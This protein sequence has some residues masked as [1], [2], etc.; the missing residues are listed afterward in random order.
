M[1]VTVNSWVRHLL[2][3]THRSNKTDRQTV[4]EAKRNAWVRT[5]Y[6]R[7]TVCQWRRA[8]VTRAKATGGRGT[9]NRMR[10]TAPL[11]RRS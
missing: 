7:D 6:N 2:R 4:D 3:Q 8:A 5:Q 11:C 9:C 10:T 1:G